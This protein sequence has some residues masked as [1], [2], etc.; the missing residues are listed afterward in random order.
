MWRSIEDTNLLV[1]DNIKVM[2]NIIFVFLKL[3]VKLGPAMCELHLKFI[4]IN[5]YYKIRK[6][7]YNRDKFLFLYLKS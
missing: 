3:L 7:K 2:T 4:L 5:F 1:H 6:N